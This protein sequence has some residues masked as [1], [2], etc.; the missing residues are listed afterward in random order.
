[1]GVQPSLTRQ[2]LTAPFVWF[3]AL[4]LIKI[5]L[6]WSVIAGGSASAML[7]DMLSVWVIFCLIETFARRRKLLYYMMVNV[8]LT[9]LFFAAI[10]YYKYYGVIVTY[11]AL[12]QVNQVTEVKDSV[13][14]LIDPQYMLIFI[15]ILVLAVLL[16]A[17]RRKLGRTGVVRLPRRFAVPGLVLLLVVCLGNVWP[18]RAS[19]N[20]LVQAEE[21]GLLNYEA[22][23]MLKDKDEALEPLAEIT[24]AAV[25]EAKGI[26]EPDEPLMRGAAAGRHV[27]V[28]QL[29]SFQALL[30][31]RELAGTALTP[32]MNALLEE[33]DYFSSFYQQVGQGNTSDAE[34]V[35]NTSLY[36]PQRGAASQIYGDKR[37]PSL[38][39]LLGAHGYAS[40]TFHTNDVHFWNRDQLYRA[41][42]FDR[43]YDQAFFGDEDTISF[44]AS[45]E[46]LYRKTAAELARLD[47][48]GESLYAHIIAVTAHHPFR[49][50]QRKLT[51]ELPAAYR[52]TLPGDYLQAQHYADEAFGQFVA[53]L[54]QNGLWERSVIVVYGDH[55]GLPM[56]ALD[57][58]DLDLLE[59]LLGRPYT[60]ADMLNVPLAIVIPGLTETG[61]VLPQPGGQS[62]ILPTLANLL[63][64]DA[65]EQVHMGQ[66]LYNHE[67]NLL[68]QRYYLPSG[69]FVT[70]EAIFIP[71]SGFDDGEVYP[72]IG[73]PPATPPT[74]AQYERALRLLHLSDSYVRQLPAHD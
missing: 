6:A 15:D 12:M 50:P 74:D 68:P 73:G 35:V 8:L 58:D 36:I 43:Y 30:L 17:R 14:T 16:F 48:E 52:D 7:T 2:A 26:K 53:A 40:A 23:T 64:V 11:H 21:M 47:A 61:R 25:R 24:P 28:V 51:L 34:Y 10:M 32:N 22:Y 31:G 55:L 20:E 19:M 3:S 63:G 9:T 72:A 54:K 18:H 37:L 33:A 44:G 60:Y 13:F 67:T 56:H 27:I 69:S 41:L 45:D 59:E 38:P 57:D 39:R 42:G 66:D 65:D 70:G 5:A 49:L 29:E 46:V 62:D 71:G 4:M 1:M